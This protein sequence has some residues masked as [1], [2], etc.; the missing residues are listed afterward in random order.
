MSTN[1][2]PL[3]QEANYLEDEN[4]VSIDN[5]SNPTILESHEQYTGSHHN[6]S[7]DCQTQLHDELAT[8]LK[9]E[10]VEE[11]LDP[12]DQDTLVF[13]SEESEEELFNTTIDITSYDSAITMG[14]PVTTA[15]ISNHVQIPREQVGCLQVTSQ[16]QDFLDQY[17]PKS[18][19]KPF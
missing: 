16:L 5:A 6:S 9:E 13:K 10:E 11:Q 19:E 2:S 17:P 12:A 14:K 18:T 7:S 1:T 8:I 4:E 3:Q 15:F